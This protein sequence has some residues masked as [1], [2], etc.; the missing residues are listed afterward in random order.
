MIGKKPIHLL[1]ED[2]R[3]KPAEIKHMHI[4]IGAG[5]REEAE[6]LVSV[7]DPAVLAAEPLPAAERP[8]RLALDGQPPRLLRRAR[9][10][11]PHRRG[12]CARRSA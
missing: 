4:D 8:A 9:G 11:P 10:R 5:K 3:K 7:G 2:D 12:R 1:E 6:E